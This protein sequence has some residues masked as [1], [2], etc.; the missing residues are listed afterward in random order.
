MRPGTTGVVG[1]GAIG[2]GQGADP[3]FR[4]MGCIGVPDWDHYGA[5][6]APRSERSQL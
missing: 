3:H 5:L 2:L 4:G 1:L 6:K